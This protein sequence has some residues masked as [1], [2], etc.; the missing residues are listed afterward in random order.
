MNLWAQFISHPIQSCGHRI[1]QYR[2]Y[3]EDAY[4]AVAAAESELDV[5]QKLSGFNNALK[6][7]SSGSRSGNYHLIILNS[8]TKQVEIATYGVKRLDEANAAYSDMEKKIADGER[9]EVVL[10]SAGP[11]DALRKA[12]PNY[13]LDTEDFILEVKKII[14]TIRRLPIVGE[15]KNF[16]LKNL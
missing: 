11:I 8:D 9:L 15:P 12:Y 3:W 14:E 2:R 4:E 1:R 7:T 10:V 5:L 13:F 6:S 16:G